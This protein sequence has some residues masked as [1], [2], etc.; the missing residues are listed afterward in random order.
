MTTQTAPAVDVEQEYQDLVAEEQRLDKK[1]LRLRRAGQAEW[2]RR[3]Q[4]EKK[5]RQPRVRKHFD[6]L[7]KEWLDQLR[8]EMHEQY[9]APVDQARQRIKQIQ[10]RRIEL[11]PQIE[12]TT[13][14]TM[15]LL[16]T[17]HPDY[18]S[19]M[20]ASGKAHRYADERH[21]ELMEHCP[22]LRSEVRQIK[23]DKPVSPWAAYYYELYANLEPWR[24]EAH[25]IVR[26]MAIIDFLNKGLPQ[27]VFEKDTYGI[28]MLV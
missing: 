14:D 5:R 23:I 1:E 20:S 6:P 27:P 18:S 19:G 21:K 22:H 8:T 3:A 15:H 7:P 16:Y 13:A 4:G 10:A 9:V 11:A 26:A 17:A 2:E 28:F 25:R 12:M 24:Y